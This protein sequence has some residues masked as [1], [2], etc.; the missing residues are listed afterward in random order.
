MKKLSNLMILLG[1]IV[2][3]SNLF[4]INDS[5][6]LVKT[7][8]IKFSKMDYAKIVAASI[9]TIWFS[10]ASL[11]AIEELQEKPF[12]PDCLQ[13]PLIPIFIPIAYIARHVFEIQGSNQENVNT[14]LKTSGIT[15][16]ILATGSGLYLWKKLSELRKKQA[17][18][19]I[20]KI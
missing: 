1:F 20:G 19:E 15:A 5:E 18:A 2:L 4:G 11:I 7:E 9:G 12:L 10:L 8:K 6:K 14:I 17:N 3:N 16:A 13:V